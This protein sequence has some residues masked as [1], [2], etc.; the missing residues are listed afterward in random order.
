M[1]GVRYHSEALANWSIHVRD[2]SVKLRWYSE[3]IGAIA[4][5][6][7][8]EW[9]EVPAVFDRFNGVRAQTWLAALRALRASSKRQAAFDEHLVFDAIRHIEEINGAAMRRSGPG[10]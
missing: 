4:V 1:F 6:L 8:G 3:D 9:V 5:E 10:G 7:D 2:R